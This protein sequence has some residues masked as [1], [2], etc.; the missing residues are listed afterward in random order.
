MKNIRSLT[1][2]K[3]G[4]KIK[5]MELY[6]KF[7]STVLVSILFALACLISIITLSIILLK[8]MQKIEDVCMEIRV[9][10]LAKKWRLKDTHD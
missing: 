6:E 10:E 8:A 4:C 7:L 5:I 2:I 1:P 3:Q 9:M